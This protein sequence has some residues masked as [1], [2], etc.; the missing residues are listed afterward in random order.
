MN[1]L[2]LGGG[3]T[4]LAAGIASNLPVFEAHTSPGGICS[5]YYI[6]PGD[7]T[8]LPVAP[9]DG[10]AYRF[11]LGGGH[12]LFGGDEA[13]LHF[14]QN[15]VPLQTYTRS[16]SIYFSADDLYVPYPL[17][18]N[19][20]YLPQQIRANALIEMSRP[21]GSYVTMKQWQRESFGDTLC[22]K[23]FFPFHELYTAGLYDQ[24]A[25][26][27]GYKSPVNLS[28]A[29]Q[30][31]FES[32][33]QVGYNTSYVYPENGLN[34]LTQCMSNLCDIRFKK[35]VVG[36]DVNSRVVSFADGNEEQYDELISTLPLNKTL[37]L[38]G[39]SV[40]AAADPYVSVLVLNIGAVKADKC[41]GDHWCYTPDTRSG[42][43][44]VGFYSNVDRSFMPE[45][46]REQHNRTSI[47]V[48]R[49]Y[50]GG[51]KPSDTE[52]KEFSDAVISEL[53]DWG[54][55]SSIEVVDP[56]WIDVAY[57]WSWP[58]SQWQQQSLGALQQQGIHMVGRYGRWKFQGIADSIR[59]GF[60]A[61]SCFK[62]R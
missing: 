42:F 59:D 20:R 46:A 9:E 12:W 35:R 8:R 31:A 61:G 23:F 39:V 62:Q 55:I 38:S 52:I 44:R 13:I 7:S 21:S 15:L 34:E 45:S 1:N 29:V 25:P 17:Q 58:G 41:P 33:S 26:Q 16:S 6:R 19:L 49:A 57:T 60:V 37:E 2:I 24:I 43:H 53:Q 4:G 11:E 22:E 47:Y 10:E 40:N 18:H 32:T 28:L 27:D 48:E 50:P 36:I 51:N 5:S 14:I 54:Y 56:T 3:V 30:G